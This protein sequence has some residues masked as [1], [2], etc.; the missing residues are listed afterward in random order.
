MEK[1][2]LKQT[3]SRKTVNDAAPQ[4][5]LVSIGLP[6]FNEANFI[7]ESVNSLLRQDYQNIEIIISDNFSNDGTDLIINNLCNNDT[8]VTFNRF[9]SNRG[10]NANFKYVYEKSKGTYFMWASGHDIWSPNLISECV[11]KLQLNPQAVL[12]FATPHAIDSNNITTN[13]NTGWTDTRGL[14]YISRFNAILWGSM[15][16]ILGVIRREALPSSLEKYY[17]G[18]GAD[19]VLLLEL[20]LKG[21]FIHTNNTKFYRRQPRETETYSQKLNRYKRSEVGIINSRFMKVF[22]LLRLPYE[23]INVVFKADIF[24]YTRISILLILLPSFPIRY[25]SGRCSK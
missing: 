8:R 11:K 2:I 1:S 20:V 24:W 9:N 16:P 7:E 21:D 17:A 18:V 14:G 13:F 12:A 25:I 19:L 22:P 6:V 4:L 10:A 5:P 23:I 15:N 3:I